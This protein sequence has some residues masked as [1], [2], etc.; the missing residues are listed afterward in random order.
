MI[1]KPNHTDQHFVNGLIKRDEKVI[2][3]IYDQ[4][5]EEVYHLGVKQYGKKLITVKVAFEKSLVAIWQSAQ[6]K[7]FTLLTS[8]RY[9]LILTFLI[10]LEKKGKEEIQLLKGVASV[11]DGIG[12][13]EFIEAY[14]Q[15]MKIV[16]NFEEYE[17]FKTKFERL[18]KAER[19]LI[20]QYLKTGAIQDGVEPVFEKIFNS[21]K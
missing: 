8:F 11:L 15:A 2:E 18:P 20:I 10:F 14:R 9:L 3:E 12:K 1:M 7:K 13:K 21:K 5:S 6:E 16:E 19:L 17:R 4:F